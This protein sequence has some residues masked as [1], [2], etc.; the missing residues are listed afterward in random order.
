MPHPLQDY[1]FGSHIDNKNT[2]LV[3][4][5]GSMYNHSMDNNVDYL[6]CDNKHFLKYIA[7]RF[8][9]AHEELFINY[10]INHGVNNLLK[11]NNI[12]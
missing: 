6:V 9:P 3:F 12:F 11:N 10:G 2:V 7:N 8:I 5:Y 1:V 4:G